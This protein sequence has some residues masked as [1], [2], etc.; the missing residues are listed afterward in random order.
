[1]VILHSSMTVKGGAEEVT[2]RLTSAWRGSGHA[3]EVLSY[4]DLPRLPPRLRRVVM[5]WFVLCWLLRSR[6]GSWADVIDSS[7]GDTWLYGRLTR[8]ASRHALLVTRSH[9]LEPLGELAHQRELRARG[10]RPGRLRQL[11]FAHWLLWEVRQSL[12]CADLVRVLS[13]SERAYCVESLGL[14]PARVVVGPNGFP[15]ELAVDPGQLTAG[16]MRL[17]MIGRWQFLK[18]S[19]EARDL[20]AACLRALPE[21]R[22]SIL[23]TGAAEPA[24]LADFPEDVRARVTVVASYPPDTLS[25]LLRGHHIYLSMSHSEGFSLGLLE[26][27]ACGLAPVVTA[28]GA[29]PDLIA[30]GRNGRLVEVGDVAAAVEAVRALSADDAGLEAVR[31]AAR[32]SVIELSWSSVAESTLAGYARATACRALRTPGS[33]A[34]AG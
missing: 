12:R 13:S 22:A 15:D 8:R 16:G 17:A 30:D 24:V 7:T 26:A 5:A 34:T 1:V 19:A 28:V 3:V 4:D 29:A 27:M 25:E 10:R 33:R 32:S 9:G 23:G 21:A 2:R 6:A 11:Y 18:G 20:V 31:R 14:P